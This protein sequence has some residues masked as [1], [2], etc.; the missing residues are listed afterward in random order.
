MSLYIAYKLVRQC[1]ECYSKSNGT[2]PELCAA[3]KKSHEVFV[4]GGSTCTPT[5]DP[6]RLAKRTTTNF[7]PPTQAPTYI[8]TLTPVPNQTPPNSL[9]QGPHKYPK[10]SPKRPPQKTYKH[11]NKK[12]TNTPRK[13]PPPPKKYPYKY[14]HKHPT[15]TQQA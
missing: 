13:H 11:P 12:T 2:I 6:T 4:Y 14:P 3:F 1:H 9:Q 7:P 15:I 8:S 10:I 5:S